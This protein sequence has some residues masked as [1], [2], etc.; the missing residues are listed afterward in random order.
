MAP[1]QTPAV[2][3]L[4]HAPTCLLCLFCRNPVPSEHH[5]HCQ[6]LPHCPGQPLRP[7]STWGIQGRERF[8]EGYLAVPTPAGMAAPGGCLLLTWDGS[9]QDFGLPKLRLL[10]GVDDV[11][12]HGQLTAASQLGWGAEM[13]EGEPGWGQG[14][15]GDAGDTHGVAIDGGDDGFANK[16]DLVP[17]GKEAAAVVL[18]E[19]FILHFLDV[20]ASCKGKC[21]GTPIPS[22]ALG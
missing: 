7:T 21:S 1:P 3:G 9:Q 16:G 18:L 11:A 5:L 14:V 6:R 17:P 8:R 15:Q 13:S 10:P 20:C 19:G 22:K 4:S 2:P 12:H